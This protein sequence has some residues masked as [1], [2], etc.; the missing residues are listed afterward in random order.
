[1]EMA[2]IADT[3]QAGAPRE[4]ID[5]VMISARVARSTVAAQQRAPGDKWRSP[6]V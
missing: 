5:Q 4:T 3:R 6:S 1:M 2:F